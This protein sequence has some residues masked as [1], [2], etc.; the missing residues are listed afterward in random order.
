MKRFIVVIGLFCASQPLSAQVIPVIAGEHDEFTRVV[1]TL[2]NRISWDVETLDRKIRIKMPKGVTFDVGRLFEQI[3]K[4]RISSV[5]SGVEPNSLDI[6][7]N[8]NCLTSTFMHQ[9]VYLVLDI[10]PSKQDFH[11]PLTL[12]SALQP[13]WQEARKTV[14]SISEAEILQ[15]RISTIQPR[16]NELIPG[17]LI[18]EI[19][20]ATLDGRIELRGASRPQQIEKILS[21]NKGDIIES[22][23]GIATLQANENQAIA[24]SDIP[25]CDENRSVEIFKTSSLDDSYIEVSTKRNEIFNEV[26]NPQYAKIVTLVVAQLRLGLSAEAY[27][28]LKQIP[29]TTEESLNLMAISKLLSSD[30]SP[31]QRLSQFESCEN[32][33]YLWY[34]LQSQEV[35]SFPVK[36]NLVLLQFKALPYWLQK[37]IFNQTITQLKGYGRTGAVQEITEYIQNDQKARI[38]EV[39]V[40]NSQADESIIIL[41]NRDQPHLM[42]DLLTEAAEGKSEATLIQLSEA[43][44]F[45]HQHTRLWGELM[46]A[47][48]STNIAKKNYRQ[49]FNSIEEF[50]QEGGSN[51]DIET[52]IHNL[53]TSI[54]EDG[55]NV[56]LIAAYFKRDD[57]RL[58]KG[59]L[60]AL[61]NR[62]ETLGITETQSIQLIDEREPAGSQRILTEQIENS[63]VDRRIISQDLDLSSALINNELLASQRLKA[64]VINM[65]PANQ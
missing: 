38:P 47:E 32:S 10:G 39:N 51:V 22:Q 12:G 55:S 17:S 43:V 8:C 9:D 46:N 61:L 58:R 6:N 3:N 20:K 2:P 52:A 23:I 13:W 1:L 18:Q 37:K 11:L 25:Q 5:S 28:V 14:M 29:D 53:Y 35:I 4:D 24:N 49:A 30:F 34:F 48:I 36:E 31:Q 26:G 62:A 63:P 45:E 19:A 21:G 16:I 15:N 56:D 40:R 64:D 59:T 44:R 57:W 60:E 33:L 27:Y 41:A 50:M 65:F 54:I 42:V 7:L